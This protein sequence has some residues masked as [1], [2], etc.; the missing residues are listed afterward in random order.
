MRARAVV[1]LRKPQMHSKHSTAG[2]G[3]RIVANSRVV[4]SGAVDTAS[5]L[6]LSQVGTIA[7]CVLDVGPFATDDCTRRC[8][9]IV[10]GK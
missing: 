1:F 9:R 2:E 5:R 4:Q 8:R 10:V 3:S 7:G 6:G